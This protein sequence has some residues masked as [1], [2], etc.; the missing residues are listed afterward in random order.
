MSSVA[1]RGGGVT[2]YGQKRP[3]SERFLAV[4]YP[5][6]ARASDLR[7]ERRVP[8]FPSERR[9]MHRFDG[10]LAR[11]LDFDNTSTNA[12]PNGPK[13]AAVKLATPRTRQRVGLLQGPDK[14]KVLEKRRR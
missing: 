7:T 14:Y 6:T 2:S 3:S 12:S 1:S 8:P 5:G 9:H 10:V 4:T 11:S 13:R